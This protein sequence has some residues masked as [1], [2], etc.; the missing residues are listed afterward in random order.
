LG[1]IAGGTKNTSH[2]KALTSCHLTAVLDL[3]S[4][5][6]K[7]WA[8]EELGNKV[9]VPNDDMSCENYFVNSYRRLTDGRFEVS[10]P[11]QNNPINLGRS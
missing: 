8:I 9:T 7:F 1:W 2:N 5:V 3:E 11:F 6:A 10:L 4:E